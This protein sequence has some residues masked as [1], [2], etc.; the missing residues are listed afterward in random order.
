MSRPDFED[1]DVYK[2]AEKL[3]NQVW[4]IVKEWDFFTKD[5]MG[6]QLVR[7]ADSVCA[8]IAEGRGR[9]NY[10]DNRRFVKIA[11]GSL[12]ETISL[13]RL[14]YARKLL[15][16]EQVNKFQPIIDDLS[17]KLNA[18]LNS[19]GGKQEKMIDKISDIDRK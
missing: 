3:A 14:A 15:G 19:I 6:K 8:N 1:L 4:F 9:Y 5:T 11:R 10:Q 2:L 17:P 18:Y 13:L 12:Y 7:A 16:I